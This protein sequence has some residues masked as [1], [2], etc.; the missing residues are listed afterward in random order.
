MVNEV[1]NIVEVLDKSRI[2]ARMVNEVERIV[3]TLDTSRLLARM[4]NE[5]EHL[6]ETLIVAR[7]RVQMLAE[8]IH[9]SEVMNS[10]VGLTRSI[11]DTVRLT[12]VTNRTNLLTRAVNE[13]VRVVEVVVRSIA[14]DV[15]RV[16]NETVRV[17]EANLRV[18]TPEVTRVINE[19]V[20]AVE[21]LVTQ[22]FINRMINEGTQIADNIL[23]ARVMVRQ[24]VESLRISEG[25]VPY[26]LITNMVNEAMRIGENL[27]ETKLLAY[28]VNEFE[29][30]TESFLQ[31][32]L[33]TRPI[34]ETETSS[35]GLT[36]DG[37]L[38]VTAGL[39][40]RLDASQLGLADGAAV[41]SWPNIAPGAP[42][43]TQPSIVGLPRPVIKTGMAPS[44]RP[45]VRFA[46]G[47][48]R[49]RGAHGLDQAYTILYVTR[50][51]GPNTGRAFTVEYPK[52]NFLVGF[53]VLV[54]DAMYDANWV[55]PGVAYDTFPGAWKLYGADGLTSVR[56]RFFI[57]GVLSGTLNAPQGMGSTYHLSG[58]DL[59]GTADTM[60]C[61]VAELLIYDHMLTNAERI[62]V[63]Q[64]L[65]AKWLVTHGSVIE[66]MTL[67]RM[68]GEVVRISETLLP[69]RSLF[70]WINETVQDSET[71]LFARPLIR[72]IV[73]TISVV[74]LRVVSRPLVRLLSETVRVVEG[75]I[76]SRTV[77]RMVS[78]VVNV[79]EV[80]VVDVTTWVIR[81]VNEA[82]QAA[83][84]SLRAL[85]LTR[86]HNA[87]VSFEDLSLAAR[88]RIQVRDD[89][90][91]LDEAPERSLELARPVDEQLT[92]FEDFLLARD[93]ARLQD[94]DETL[95]EDVVP[96]RSRVQMVSEFLHLD[97]VLKFWVS[98]PSLVCSAIKLY[99]MF[100]GDAAIAPVLLANPLTIGPEI[101]GGETSIT[102]AVEGATGITPA[103][104][105]NT[106]IDPAVEAKVEIEE[107]C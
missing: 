14:T 2:L 34:N 13:T 12:E 68:I 8:T 37:G 17:I 56:S 55:N 61:E 4:V 83:E 78:E 10:A 67:A 102:V 53:H 28:M 19:A 57:N 73:E 46:A 106:G 63:E 23:R 59:T 82:V 80:K 7:V 99:A 107:C 79:G 92:V 77:A 100:A 20:R 38:P 94:E 6:N 89:T 47:Q 29:R 91:S 1:V 104:D 40:I 31:P 36:P 95:S 60:D 49:L 103:V 18:I 75:L 87:I 81:M 86:T 69:I 11:S 71:F 85:G 22:Q 42:A 105:G 74:D 50:A 26:K 27:V 30:F 88:L 15:T 41:T 25:L 44:G 43:G 52:R 32:R 33:L 35:D 97:E 62:S 5:V 3:E 84:T 93:L 45:V 96:T 54:Q 16:V 9:L 70:R 72:E 24:F 39:L 65:T 58:F 76:P 21:V 66:A 101:E 64:Y 51:W 90:V 48:G 98:M